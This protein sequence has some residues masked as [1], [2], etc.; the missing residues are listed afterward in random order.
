MI[1]EQFKH[2]G[3]GIDLKLGEQ[4]PP[5]VGNTYKFEQVIVNLLTN[6]KDAVVREK[7]QGFR[8]CSEW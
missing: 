4:I 2:L 3:I 7:K 8:V 1:T 5:L 6:A